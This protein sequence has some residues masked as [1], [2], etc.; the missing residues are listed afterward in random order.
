LDTPWTLMFLTQLP[1]LFLAMA[2]RIELP[3]NDKN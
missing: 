2:Y 1:T 3:G